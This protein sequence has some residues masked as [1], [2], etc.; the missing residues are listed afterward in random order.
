MLT[1][2]N[3]PAGITGAWMRVAI[4]SSNSIPPVETA[5]AL[6]VG[7]SSNIIDAE[8]LGSR[9]SGRNRV[10]AAA[11]RSFSTDRPQTGRNVAAAVTEVQPR[12]DAA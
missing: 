5:M 2:G 6:R 8:R 9:G 11:A 4:L 3:E 10:V 1:M 7:A 12:H